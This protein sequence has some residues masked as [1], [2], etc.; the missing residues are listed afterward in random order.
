MKVNFA[1]RTIVLTKKEMKQASIPY[2]QEYQMLLSL[3]RDLP[4]FKVE[5]KHSLCRSNANRGLC[6]EAMS[7]RIAQEAPELMDEFVAVRSVAGYPAASQ[8]FRNHFAINNQMVDLCSS[9][10][11][12][13]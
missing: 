3:M 4:D 1:H 10:G 8:W 7:Q 12:A 2:T 9:L 13:A 11:L 6:Y 5:I